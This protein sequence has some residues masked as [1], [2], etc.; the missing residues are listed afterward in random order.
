M[1]E[2]PGGPQHERSPS[3]Q[4]NS[5]SEQLRTALAGG[6]DHPLNADRI[7]E[8]E[9]S[10]LPSEAPTHHAVHVLGGVGDVRRHA[11]RRRPATAR[12]S[13]EEIVRLCRCPSNSARTRS[14]ALAAVPVA[15]SEG[16]RGADCGLYSSVAGSSVEDARLAVGIFDALVESLPRL[17]AGE[18]TREHLIHECRQDEYA[19]RRSVREAVAQVP[20]DVTEN[21]DARQDP[22]SG[23]WR[24]WAG[25]A[26]AR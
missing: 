9:W 4:G 26:R 17:L 13:R 5:V 25:R 20:Y 1:R 24:S 16:S 12:V 18:A 7:D 10:E 3:R 19:A 21:V 2:P 14:A 11:W 8:L 23:T 15:S 22:A 6:V